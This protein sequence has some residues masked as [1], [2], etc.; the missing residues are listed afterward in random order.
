MPRPKMFSVCLSAADREFLV[1]PTTTGVHSARMIMRAQVLL[2]L[3]EDAIN[4]TG[5][6]GNATQLSRDRVALSDDWLGIVGALSVFGFLGGEVVSISFLGDSWVGAVSA[7][8]SS[9][10]CLGYGAFTVLAL[11]GGGKIAAGR[12]PAG[13]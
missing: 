2:E 1:K 7:N 5:A 12:R 3:D 10:E 9:F 13:G 8:V 4:L 11:C 6:V